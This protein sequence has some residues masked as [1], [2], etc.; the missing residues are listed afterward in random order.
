MP[1]PIYRKE[2]FAAFLGFH[3]S[4]EMNAEIEAE[5]ERALHRKSD[6]LRLLLVEGLKG[7]RLSQLRHG[8]GELGKVVGLAASRAAAKRGE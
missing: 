5:A 7:W 8:K 3:V 2:R 4:V 6:F 1:R